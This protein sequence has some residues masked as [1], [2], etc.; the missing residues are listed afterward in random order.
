V[1]V[2]SGELVDAVVGLLNMQSWTVPL[3]A[4]KRL[5]L[6]LDRNLNPEGLFVAAG[7]DEWTKVTRS[8]VFQ[9]TKQVVVVVR[10]PVSDNNAP[11]DDLMT[12]TEEIKTYLSQRKPLAMPCV[13]VTQEE[14]F[15]AD[16][17]QEMALFDTAIFFSFRETA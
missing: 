16:T 10:K 11:L 13:E 17:L 12:T 2:N 15:S 7:P 5:F 8:A 6:R 4:T 1:P 14:P 9:R 3:T